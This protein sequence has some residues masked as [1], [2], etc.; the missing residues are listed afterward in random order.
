M[1]EKAEKRGPGHPMVYDR[2]PIVE[3][4]CEGLAK[5]V[6]LE[7]ICRGEGMP[8]SRQI[9]DWKRSDAAIASA[10]AHA[11][12]LGGDVI[13]QRLRNTARGLTPDKG[14]DSTGDVQRD[15]LIVN[16]DLKLLAKWF[17][18]QYGDR[19]ALTN[20]K[21]DGDARIEV[22]SLADQLAELINITPAV[23]RALPSSDGGDA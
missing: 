8:C 3:R 5:G 12:E 13:A 17:P 18:A 9:H 6:P 19:M 21:G 22:V 23:A 11:R 2:G 20:A 10:I 14:G 4:V 15:A 7:E 16:T 1:S